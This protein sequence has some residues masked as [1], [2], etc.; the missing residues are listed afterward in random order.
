MQHCYDGDS[1]LGENCVSPSNLFLS[2]WK[3]QPKRAESR[4]NVLAPS[5]V[6]PTYRFVFNVNQSN[7][8]FHHKT[9]FHIIPGVL[10]LRSPCPPAPQAMSSHILIRQEGSHRKRAI[11]STVDR[12]FSLLQLASCMVPQHHQE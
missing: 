3:R 6:K 9:A 10:L 4:G 8:A 2:I 1:D 11:D 12:V 7:T 5:A